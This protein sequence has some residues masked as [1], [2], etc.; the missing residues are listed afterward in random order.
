MS[1]Y[2]FL[3][4]SCLVAWAAVAT[5]GELHG[6]V[7]LPDGTP[8]AGADVSA[9]GM[10]VKPALRLQTTTDAKGQFR[11]DLKPL[12]G[13]QRRS[14]CTARVGWEA[15]QTTPMELSQSRQDRI[16]RPL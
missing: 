5:A 6:T 10:F 15:R 16:R 3:V 12:S 1:G 14:V 13:A 4:S 11:L 8:A 9:A 7:L 2:R